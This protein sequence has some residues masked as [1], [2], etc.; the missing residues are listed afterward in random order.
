MTGFQKVLAGWEDSD[1]SLEQDTEPSGFA[2]CSNRSADLG[3]S[4]R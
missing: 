3:L 1:Q 2:V 4:C